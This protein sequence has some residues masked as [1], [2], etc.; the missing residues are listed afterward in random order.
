MTVNKLLFDIFIFQKSCLKKS[1]TNG[2]EYTKIFIELQT[3]YNF[4][5][6]GY[7]LVRFQTHD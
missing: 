5:A 6:Q 7:I 3:M 4:P 1:T 2:K